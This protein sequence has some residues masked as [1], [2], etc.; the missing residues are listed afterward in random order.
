M[1]FSLPDPMVNELVLTVHSQGKKLS[2]IYFI[3]FVYVIHHTCPIPSSRNAFQNSPIYKLLILV[4][5][6]SHLAFKWFRVYWDSQHTSASNTPLM[7]KDG[8]FQVYIVV[9]IRCKLKASRNAFHS[10]STLTMFLTDGYTLRQDLWKFDPK[11]SRF[12]KHFD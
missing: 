5:H 12:V 4:L 10:S 7:Q 8:F 9:S 2:R 1:G 3:F 6:G 11:I